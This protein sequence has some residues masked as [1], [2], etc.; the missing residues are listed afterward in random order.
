MTRFVNKAVL[1]P[2]VHSH[3]AHDQI[4]DNASDGSEFENNFS[5]N[6]VTMDNPIEDVDGFDDDWGF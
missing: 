3:L 6:D 5:D 2:G 4:L 1:W